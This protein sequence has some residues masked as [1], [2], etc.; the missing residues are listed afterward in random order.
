VKNAR[1][2]ANMSGLKSFAI[3][4]DIPLD[5]VK[6]KCGDLGVTLNEFIF[7]I[8]SQTMK[9]CLEF[10]D[11]RETKAIR[12]AMPF[13]LRPTPKHVLDFQPSNDFAILPV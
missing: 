10:H 9:Q 6:A 7:G 11:D 8:I 5:Y 1:V 2:E 13:S 3:A 12:V 4:K